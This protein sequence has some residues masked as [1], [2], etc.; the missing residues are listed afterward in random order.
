MSVKNWQPTAA[1]VPVLMTGYF[2]DTLPPTGTSYVTYGNAHRYAK[3]ADPMDQEDDLL[4][5][6]PEM[7]E[8]IARL[9]AYINILQED[10]R[11]MAETQDRLEEQL[12]RVSEQVREIQQRPDGEVWRK[13]KLEWERLV[14]KDEPYLITTSS[15]MPTYNGG[16]RTNW[17][18]FK[19]R[20]VT[21]PL[22]TIVTC[23]DTTDTNS[24][25]VHLLSK[26]ALKAQT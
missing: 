17:Q 26:D 2:R 8:K 6:G 25:K 4:P 24:T 1:G 11:R 5:T 22:G 18:V 21:Q 3:P 15:T 10:R 7:I 23:P 20:G 9:E 13:Q 16:P 14:Y 19:S 12:R